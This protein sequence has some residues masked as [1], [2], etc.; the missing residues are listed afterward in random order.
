MTITTSSISALVQRSPETLIWRSLLDVYPQ[1]AAKLDSLSDRYQRDTFAM[2]QVALDALL[3]YDRSTL[4][5]EGQLDYD[6]YEWYLQDVVD[7]LPFI[8]HDF[9]ASYGLFGA[10]RDTEQLFTEVHPLNVMQDAEDYVTRLG[11]VETKFAQLV[12]HLVNA[13]TKWHRRAGPDNAGRN[14]P[15]CCDGADARRPESLL[16]AAG[17]RH[18]QHPG[19][20]PGTARPLAEP[21]PEYG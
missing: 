1:A 17:R 13:A 8:Y 4:D 10:Q 2:Y 20:R 11:R 12:D 15:G 6:V 16:H 7:R 9:A 19:I 14:Q 5:A 18:R 3:T 21:G